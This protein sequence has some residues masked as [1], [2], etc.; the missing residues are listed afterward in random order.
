MILRAIDRFVAVP[1]PELTRA[2]LGEQ[3]ISTT[4]PSEITSLTH[5]RE[6]P[7]VHRRP[8]STYLHPFPE[9]NRTGTRVHAVSVGG[10]GPPAAGNASSA[11]GLSIPEDPGCWVRLWW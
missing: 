1:D 3:L 4:E 10:W 8:R 5:V 2:E 7:G 11:D 6:F 9:R